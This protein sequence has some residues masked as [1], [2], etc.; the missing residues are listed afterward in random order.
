MPLPEL[1]RFIERW[2]IKQKAPKNYYAYHHQDCG[3]KYRGCHPTLCP[4]NEYEKTGVWNRKLIK[5]FSKR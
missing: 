5:R 4:K 3:T 2:K 1:R